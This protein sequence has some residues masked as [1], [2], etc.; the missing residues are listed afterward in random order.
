MLKR[1]P[2]ASP[3]MFR[4]FTLIELLVVIAIIAILAAM[5]L[6]A[7][8]KAREQAKKSS[9][10]SNLSQLGKYFL[11]YANDFNGMAP[12]TFYTR[13]SDNKTISWSTNLKDLGYI[14]TVNAAF[15]RC[16][17]LTTSTIE[18]ASNSETYGMPNNYGDSWNTAKIY[19]ID[20]PIYRL[21][22]QYLKPSRF[23]ILVD[24]CVKTNTQFRQSYY[25]SWAGYDG[26]NSSKRYIH[27][28]HN[29]DANAVCAAGN[30][31]TLNPQDA[32]SKLDWGVDTYDNFAS[33]FYTGSELDRK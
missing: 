30:V 8:N 7:L 13:T 16:P 33:Y 19:K 11:S 15:I 2:K 18:S 26:A 4:K 5:L 1:H 14:S 23:L 9:C 31:V 29:G 32:Q 6:P 24:S 25:I 10:A 21:S 27:T 22:D 17:Y 3:I 20:R 12:P 28:R